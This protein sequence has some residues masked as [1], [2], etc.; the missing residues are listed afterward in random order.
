MFVAVKGTQ[1]DGHAY[2]EK[3]IENG[4]KIL[5]NTEKVRY[6]TY[7][8]KGGIPMKN[9]NWNEETEFTT[10]QAEQNESQPETDTQEEYADYNEEG[11]YG[12]FEDEEEE[13]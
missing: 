7:K 6:N 1:T 2:I 13:E 10:P 9:T 4:I 3:A 8:Y 12:T 11:L 5:T